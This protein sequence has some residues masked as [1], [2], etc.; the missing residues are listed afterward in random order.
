[1]K[2]ELSEKSL[3][4]VFKFSSSGHALSHWQTLIKRGDSSLEATMFIKVADPG[5]YDVYGQ[6]R[7]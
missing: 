4:V 7:F 6:V 2:N 1:M 5:V 3:K